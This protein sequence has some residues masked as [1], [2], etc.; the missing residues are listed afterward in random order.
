MSAGEDGAATLGPY[1]L[2]GLLGQGA[3]SL[4]HRAVDTR[5]GRAV[6]V[7]T[8]RPELLTAGERALMMGRFQREADLGRK[9]VH[10]HLVR[11]RDHGEGPDGPF[12]VMDILTGPTLKDVIERDAPLPPARVLDLVLPVLD[13]L[14]HAHARGVVHR[15]VKPANVLLLDNESRP[16]LMDFGI[17]AARDGATADLT[18]VGDMLGTPAYMAPEQ[19]QGLA[20]SDR[21]DVF[22]VGVVL[23]AMLTGERAFSGTLASIMQGILFEE[24]PPP[25][26]TAAWLPADLD[27]V[28]AAALTKDPARR[29]DALGL[30]RALSSLAT[31]LASVM[32][33]AGAGVA[34]DR[35][36]AARQARDLAAVD[37]SARLSRLREALA[38]AL[39]QA[40]AKRLGQ[41]QLRDIGVLLEA[42]GESLGRLDPDVRQAVSA[43]LVALIETRG[44]K[45]ALEIALSGA[46]L[47]GRPVRETRR[48][49]MG[50]VRLLVLLSDALDRVGDSPAGDMAL[51]RVAGEIAD[52]V[53][54]HAAR[55]NAS[56][57]EEDGPDLAMV[58]ADFMRLDVLCLALEEIGAD[59]ERASAEAQ[60]AA[61]ATQVMRKVNAVIRHATQEG[62]ALARFGMATMLGE[63][64]DLIALAQRLLEGGEGGARQS[65]RAARMARAVVADFIDNAAAVAALYGSDLRAAMAAPALDTA[66]FGPRL[67]RLGHLYV[68]ASRVHGADIAPA[69]STLA[70]TVHG[71][72][73]EITEGLLRR[74]GAGE[75]AALE[76]VAVLLEMTDAFGWG[77]IRQR[78]L[79]VLRDGVM[80]RPG[81]QP[82]DRA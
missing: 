7:K 9:L 35:A 11:V 78:L 13:G 39:D 29:P 26:R 51:D 19:L 12:M 25:S 54:D 55:L 48:D 60:M 41:R 68:F 58:S 22:A 77:A 40:L 18:Q 20:V 53:M 16:I 14:A 63:V 65:G 38:H 31:M 76:I 57:G 47:P 46:P 70:E 62:D 61:L 32:P 24:P 10:P 79:V 8:L 23:Y 33:P 75:A 28:I 37:D 66:G 43:D 81:G 4:V 27:A 6:A 72:V 30:V 49:W 36:H 17:A 15:D 21:A 64:E 80:R 59:T 34:A 73:A 2:D 56:L 5:D 50:A 69:L 67:R 71:L 45:P 44:V 42:A 3:M 74:A 1:R 82:G 52:A